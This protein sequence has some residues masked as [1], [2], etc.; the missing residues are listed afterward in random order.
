MDSHK[1][2][3]VWVDGWTRSDTNVCTR[4]GRRARQFLDGPRSLGS[5]AAADGF[6]TTRQRLCRRQ[7][8]ERGDVTEQPPDLVAVELRSPIGVREIAHT[9]RHLREVRGRDKERHDRKARRPRLDERTLHVVVTGIQ[10]RH[11]H[12]GAR[13]FARRTP[14]FRATASRGAHVQSSAVVP[15]PP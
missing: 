7:E 3:G 2:L 10:E 6:L 5:R 1:G 9:A 4:D 12:G 15:S 13:A 8:L 11:R 14:A